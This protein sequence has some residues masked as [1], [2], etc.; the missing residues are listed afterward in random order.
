MEVKVDLVRGLDPGASSA[1]S[2]TLHAEDRAERRF[3]RGDDGALADEFKT[4][5]EPNGGDGLTLT[6]GGGRGRGDKDQ[7]APAREIRIVEQGELH[8]GTVR[9][10][11]LDVL[12][13]KAELLRNELDGKKISGHFTSS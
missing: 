10:K 11:L 5:D 4:L 1:G 8:L 6:R 2:A 7:F 9:A 13:R 3:A 12:R